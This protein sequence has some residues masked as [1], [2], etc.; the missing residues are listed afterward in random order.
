[1]GDNLSRVRALFTR[2]A[3]DRARKPLV[4]AT[5]LPVAPITPAPASP[6]RDRCA[7]GLA[8][9]GDPG[10]WQELVSGH[11]RACCAGCCAS[12]RSTAGGR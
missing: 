4:R 9:G 8:Y 2:P 1:M 6:T 3:T 11:L 10:V 12:D 7:C 5:A